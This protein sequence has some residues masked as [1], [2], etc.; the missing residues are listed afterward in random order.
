[1]KHKFKALSPFKDE[2]K[3]NGHDVDCGAN[4]YMTR[5]ERQLVN[6]TQILILNL[7]TTQ[8]AK[9]NFIHLNKYLWICNN[10]LPINTKHLIYF[11]S[12]K[13]AVL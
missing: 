1:M 4:A 5:V 11:L 2:N 12:L 7:S 10:I 3:K 13:M 6:Y 8:A 9:F